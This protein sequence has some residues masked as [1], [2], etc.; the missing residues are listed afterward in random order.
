MNN[1]TDNII[2]NK[3]NITYSNI[4]YKEQEVYYA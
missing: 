3:A 4:G 1:I 2:N